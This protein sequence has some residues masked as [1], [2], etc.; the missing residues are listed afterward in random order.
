MYN[1]G[2]VAS[3][4]ARN[5]NSTQRS[6]SAE[7]TFYW[8]L[9]NGIV[10]GLLMLNIL[11]SLN[12]RLDFV[13]LAIPSILVILSIVLAYECW[14]LKRRAFFVAFLF[15]LASAGIS[16]EIVYA[17]NGTLLLLIELQIVWFAYRSYRESSGSSL[18]SFAKQP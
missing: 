13:Y 6:L 10:T 17:L 4:T 1:G 2:F 14:M 8:L 18:R 5:A 15:G 3:D 9:V 7:A 12:A 16:F 11:V